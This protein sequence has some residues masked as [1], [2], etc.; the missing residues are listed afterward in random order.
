MCTAPGRWPWSHSDASRTSTIAT[1]PRSRSASASS[2]ETSRTCAR[3]SRRR[4]AYDFGICSWFLVDDG[5]PDVGRAKGSKRF[6]DRPRGRSGVSRRAPAPDT[7]TT[8]RSFGRLARGA[9]CLTA[10]GLARDRLAADRPD[11][12]DLGECLAQGV[13][14]EHRALQ[15]RRA[16]LDAEQVEQV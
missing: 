8:R 5:L 11:A 10:D 4:S 13:V 2:G 1:S 16:D 12:L 15:S 6:Y 7:C 14:A 9:D 3:A